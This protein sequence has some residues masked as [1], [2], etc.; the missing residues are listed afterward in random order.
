M[1]EDNSWVE[2]ARVQAQANSCCIS[3]RAWAVDEALDS[4]L[5]KIE[6]G[7]I[8][9][10]QQSENL[11]ANRA[12][13]QRKRRSLL[14]RQAPLMDS[15]PASESGRLEARSDLAWL[16]SQCNGQEWK[17]LVSIGLGHTYLNIAKAKQVPESTIKTRVRRARLH[18]AG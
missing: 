18:I 10:T 13:K 9:S 2:Y 1:E 8:A 3:D 6:A 14:A 7:Q 4:I 15:S 12:R 11:L 5:D 16:K 17:M